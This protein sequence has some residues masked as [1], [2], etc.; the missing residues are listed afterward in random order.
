MYATK[1][2]LN[3]LTGH[4][5]SGIE[6]AVQSLSLSLLSFL[7]VGGFLAYKYLIKEPKE[8]KAAEAFWKAQ[9]YFENDSLKQALN[10]DRQFP[11][12]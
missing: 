1:R 9:D 11:G 5:I 7:L 2:K 6:M 12:A 4:V 10:G 8:Q 3:R